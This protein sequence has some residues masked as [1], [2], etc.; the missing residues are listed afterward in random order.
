[1]FCKHCGKEIADK[2]V[3]C[4]NCGCATGY[5]ER[6]PKSQAVAFILCLLLG[7][8]GAHDLY[9]E[10]PWHCI[11]KILILLLLGWIGAGFLIVGIWVIMDLFGIILKNDPCFYFAN[12]LAEIERKENERKESQFPRPSECQKN[13]ENN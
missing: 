11:V 1:M 2:A 3:I 6:Q 4:V 8:V 9:M 10:H 7:L 12:E 13:E 5:V